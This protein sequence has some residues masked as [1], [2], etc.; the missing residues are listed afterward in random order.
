MGTGNRTCTGT[1]K[2]Y[3]LCRVQVRLR[4]TGPP[5]PSPFSGGSQVS[6]PVALGPLDT[7]SRTCHLH[8][9]EEKGGEGPRAQNPPFRHQIKSVVPTTGC[10]HLRGKEPTS[11]GGT[12]ARPQGLGS[13]GAR[14]PCAQREPCSPVSP[15]DWSHRRPP[16]APTSALC[17][18]STQTFFV[19][20]VPHRGG[21]VWAGG[22]DS[23]SPSRH[24][25][26]GPKPV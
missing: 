14:G 13:R 24:L 18:L 5:P 3:Q 15:R 10:G 7:L 26:M 22:A 25:S 8:P 2:R 4:Q 9:V 12:P 19:S 20:R 17:A 16:C 23:G 11:A 21:R 1:S 6:F